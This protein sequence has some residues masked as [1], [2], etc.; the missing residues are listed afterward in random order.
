MEVLQMTF[1]QK[2]IATVTVWASVALLSWAF[3]KMSVLTQ[4][5][6]GLLC[7]LATVLT[8][9]IFLADLRES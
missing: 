7:F 8:L 3:Y 6:V 4:H 1:W 2:Y 9:L 5:G